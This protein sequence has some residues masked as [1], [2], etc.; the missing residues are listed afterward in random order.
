[1]GLDVLKGI[2]R[3]DVLLGLNKKYTYSLAQSA[4]ILFQSGMGLAWH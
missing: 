1:M 2:C 3:A 4:A